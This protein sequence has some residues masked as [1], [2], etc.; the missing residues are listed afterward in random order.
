MS[1]PN[2]VEVCRRCGIRRPISALVLDTEKEGDRATAVH[3]FKCKRD[4]HCA[5]L[6]SISAKGEA[7][8]A[9][10]R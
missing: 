7:D 4:D 10:V 1:D 8:R 5:L 9:R 3:G 2:R 6:H